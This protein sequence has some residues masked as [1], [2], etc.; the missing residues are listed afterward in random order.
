[1]WLALHEGAVPGSLFRSRAAGPRGH[2]SEAG[3]PG[4]GDDRA[5]SQDAP[6]W[7]DAGG[8]SKNEGVY[9]VPMIS[10]T[11]GGIS[12]I[13]GEVGAVRPTPDVPRNQKQSLTP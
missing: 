3:I 8:S 12:G 2:A 6:G 10:G 1:M 5:R 9:V 13:R 4:E 7:I 11:R